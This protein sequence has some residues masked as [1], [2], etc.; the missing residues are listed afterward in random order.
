MPLQ[1]RRGTNAQRQILAVPLASGELLWTTDTQQL[2]IGDGATLANALTPVVG[3]NDENAQDAAAAIFTN[4]SHTDITFTYNEGSNT[5]DADVSLS[6]FTQNVNMSTFNLSGSG[7]ITTS[8]T[9]T[10]SAFRGDYKG[11]IVGDD[12]SVLV[13]AV[14]SK[15]NLDGT[16][17]GNIIPNAQETYDIG[18]PTNRFKDLYLSGSSLYLGDAQ[19]VSNGTAVDLPAGSTVNGI[20][21]GDPTT[22]SQFKIDIVGDDSVLIVDTSSNTLRGNFIGSVFSDS[23][24]QLIDGFT[25]EAS[26]PSAD[27]PNITASNITTNNLTSLNSY[28]NNVYSP[29]SGTINIWNL[30]S[31]ETDARV[32]G[33]FNVDDQLYL[34]SVI[35]DETGIQHTGDFTVISN[36][37]NFTVGNA[38]TTGRMRL[39]INDGSSTFQDGFVMEQFHNNVDAVDFAFYRT[40]GANGASEALQTGDEVAEIMFYGHNGTDR[41]FG[42]SQA[43]IVE[44]TPTANGMRTGLR[45]RASNGTS[46]STIATLNYDGQL[47]ID[48][49]GSQTTGEVAMQSALTLKTYANAAARDADLIAPTAGMLVYVTDVAK[50]QVNTDGTTGGWVNLH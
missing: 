22:G 14:D 6:A 3:Y 32:R 9:I 2:F 48:K 33:N 44:D 21:L 1:I 49:L 29:D 27:I 4:G 36:S 47:N 20:P 34:R 37:G 24:T 18:S 23:S 40:R 31:F 46:S 35:L 16:V 17:K 15:I 38:E 43:A 28:M 25:G 30:T 13:D 8:G 19:I 10:A 42:I 12:S 5:V 45:W 41:V 39:V 26:F 7:D 50:A 11:T